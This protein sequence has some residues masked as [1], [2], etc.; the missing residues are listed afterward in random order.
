MIRFKLTNFHILNNNYQT[1][2]TDLT[3]LRNMSWSAVKMSLVPISVM[4]S[5]WA[6]AGRGSASLSPAAWVWAG[7]RTG[8][9]VARLL[10]AASSSSESSSLLVSLSMMITENCWTLR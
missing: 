2:S 7:L 6:G 5:A 8:A 3:T 10:E 1:D 9:E 4:V